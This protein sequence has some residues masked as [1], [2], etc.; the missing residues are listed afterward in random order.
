MPAS[1]PSDARH[2]EG[3]IL[4]AVVRLARPDGDGGAVIERAAIVAE[5]APAAAIEAWVIAHG[6]EPEAP[7][8]AGPRSGLYG[9]RPDGRVVAGARPPRRYV[10]PADALT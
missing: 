10:L 7:L 5:G 2:S 8:I 3:A 6:G 4:A 9:L 1:S